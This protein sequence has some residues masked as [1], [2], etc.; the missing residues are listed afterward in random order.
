MALRKQASREHWGSRAPK[1]TSN[2]HGSY[3]FIGSK[4][5]RENKLQ[6]PRFSVYFEIESF[7]NQFS[8]HL[9]YM[10]YKL[11]LPRNRPSE[12]VTH[13]IWITHAKGVSIQTHILLIGLKNCQQLLSLSKPEHIKARTHQTTPT[14]ERKPARKGEW[15]GGATVHWVTA[16]P[17]TTYCQGSHNPLQAETL[18]QEEEV[19]TQTTMM[20]YTSICILYS[21][22]K[23]PYIKKLP[24]LSHKT[25]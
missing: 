3:T 8:E 12:Q 5:G 22:L 21:R 9:T 6:S 25:S 24:F 18:G 23:R 16:G 19:A 20:H 11:L 2:F 13:A 15:E 14:N 7:S 17:K 4:L 1:L 10:A